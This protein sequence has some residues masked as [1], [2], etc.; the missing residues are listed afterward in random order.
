MHITTFKYKLHITLSHST[1]SKRHHT[2]HTTMSNMASNRFISFGIPQPFFHILHHSTPLPYYPCTTPSF[3]IASPHFT[4]PRLTLQTSHLIPHHSQ[5]R[6][7][8]A[9]YPTSGI[10]NIPHHTKFHTTLLHHAM[11][12]CEHQY[13]NVWNDVRR[14]LMWK[15]WLLRC[16]MYNTLHHS[17][18]NTI[19]HSKPRHISTSHHHSSPYRTNTY[20]STLFHFA[21][22]YFKSHRIGHIMHHTTSRTPFLI[23]FRATFHIHHATFQITPYNYWPHYASHH[24]LHNGG[25]AF[26][27]LHILHNC[28]LPP[29]LIVITSHYHVLHNIPHHTSVH[30]HI[31]STSLHLPHLARHHLHY[32]ASRCIGRTAQDGGH[33]DSHTAPRWTMSVQKPSFRWCLMSSDVRW[34]IRDKLRPVREHGSILLYV[35]GGSLGRTAQDGHLDSHTAPEL[36]TKTGSV[37]LL[38]VLVCRLTY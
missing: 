14:G 6:M 16:A 3:H 28:I 11:W 8:K 30:R 18:S 5:I 31:L 25:T 2:H 17:T 33:L 1:Y 12:C 36:C 29:H 19:W 32:H 37:V 35:H 26:H 24:I 13:W 20:R 22:P 10:A 34:H 4:T 23:T 7:N 38:N 15:Y 27:M 21:I 9:Q